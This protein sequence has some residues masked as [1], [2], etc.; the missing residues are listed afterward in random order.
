MNVITAARQH[1]RAR[2]L[3]RTDCSDQ[4]VSKYFAVATTFYDTRRTTLK[5]VCTAINLAAVAVGVY[6]LLAFGTTIGNLTIEILGVFAVAAANSYIVWNRS[7]AA[8]LKRIRTTVG[9][10]Q[11]NC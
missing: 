8:D 9:A 10:A 11:R 4:R 2:E 5:L 7:P 6:F 1:Q 3:L